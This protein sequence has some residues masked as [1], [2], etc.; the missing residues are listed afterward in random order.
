VGLVPAA[1]VRRFKN[2]RQLLLEIDRY[3]LE[4]TNKK[5][6]EAIAATA[7]PIDAII[8]QFTAELSFASTLQRFA[9][10]Q[11]FLL[12]DFRDKDLYDNYRL[13]FEHRQTQV[14]ELLN[15]AVSEGLLD[16][17]ANT[18][19]L[20]VHLI[21]LLHGTGHVWAMKQ[22]GPIEEYITRHVHVALTPYLKRRSEMK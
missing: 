19:Q 14:T 17:S 11:E 8:A 12:M 7:S 4:Y 5:V 22:E 20:A 2:K 3:A 1:L 10:T 21:T 9:N 13:S 18:E 16:K 6:E 15:N